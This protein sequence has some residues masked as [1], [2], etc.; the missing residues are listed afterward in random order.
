MN[1]EILS[2]I[3][4]ITGLLIALFSGLLIA[5]VATIQLSDGTYINNAPSGRDWL[6]YK[7]ISNYL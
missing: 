2:H 4:G 7:I 6:E 1:L 3:A 5:Q